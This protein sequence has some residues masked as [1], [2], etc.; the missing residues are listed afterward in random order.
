MVIVIDIDGTICSKVENGEYHKAIPYADRIK[1]INILYDEGNIIK[2]FT[3]RGQWSGV[4]RREFTETQL[5]EW[6][7]K[8]HELHTNKLAGDI[9]VDDLAVS[10]DDFFYQGE[11]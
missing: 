6:G 1:H 5:K 3:A 8:F 11:L 4:D 10:P 9:Y 7:L 2:I